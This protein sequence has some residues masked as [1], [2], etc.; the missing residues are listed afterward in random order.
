MI[1]WILLFFPLFTL[2]LLWFCWNDT[3]ILIFQTRSSRLEWKLHTTV[4]VAIRVVYAVGFR[5]VPAVFLPREIRKWNSFWFCCKLVVV[6]F[7]IHALQVRCCL[8]TTRQH[9]MYDLCI[10]FLRHGCCKKATVS[11]QS[12][13]L[14][15]L[16]LPAS[17]LIEVPFLFFVVKFHKL[18]SY[19]KHLMNVGYFHDMHFSHL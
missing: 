14:S 19:M 1:R 10:L 7:P 15:E 13:T 6:G 11:L 17:W 3:I 12:G 2:L 16:H 5:A 4:S 18:C 9:G 8:S